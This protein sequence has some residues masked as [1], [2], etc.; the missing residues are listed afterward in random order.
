MG[1]HDAGSANTTFCGGFLYAILMASRSP[2]RSH[3]CSTRVRLVRGPLKA[4][5]DLFEPTNAIFV[6][7]AIHTSFSAKMPFDFFWVSLLALKFW[8][9]YS[10]QIAPLVQPTREL[11]ALDLSDWYPD[12]ELGKLPNMVV[13]IVRWAPLMI[14][15]MIDLQLWFML[16]TAMYGTIKGC[17]LHIGE[18]PDL[19]TVRERFLAAA[20]NFNQRMLSRAVGLEAYKEAYPPPAFG[21][22][23]D[24]IADA[25]GGL[26]LRAAVVAAPG[27]AVGLES[28]EIRNESLRFFAEAWNAILD[29]MRLG[30]PP[31]WSAAT[32]SSAAEGGG[33]TNFS[34][35][36][37]LPIFCTGK[38]PTS[39]PRAHVA[40]ESEGVSL[41]WRLAMEERW[42]QTS[43][44]TSAARG[45]RRVPRAHALAAAARAA[46]R[47]RARRIVGHSRPSSTTERSSR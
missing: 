34:R 7:K 43:P 11:W 29:D 6:G 35:C 44:P 14:M 33:G 28:G 19:P 3:P 30:P 46:A 12:A 38:S 22:V 18:V 10:F 24:S 16:W 26:R 45:P 40:A 20:E 8:F 25:N 5:V 36:T 41:K 37:Y 13:L 23:T 47:D 15:Y 42:T 39:S 9:S 32:W 31:N 27:A 21:K 17:Q 2:R 4:I 1:P